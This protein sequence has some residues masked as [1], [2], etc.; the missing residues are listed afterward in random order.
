MKKGIVLSVSKNPIAVAIGVIVIVLVFKLDSLFKTLSKSTGEREELD[1]LLEEKEAVISDEKARSLADG[2]Y[3]VMAE[4]FKSDLKDVLPYLKDLSQADFNKVYN[5]FEKRQYSKFW[6]NEGDPVTSGR[7]DLI[8]WLNSE[9][10][11]DGMDNLRKANTS[12]RI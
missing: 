9:L 6:G 1:Q 11:A 5:K 4:T 3:S 8:F 10:Q 7:Y 2:L 12:L